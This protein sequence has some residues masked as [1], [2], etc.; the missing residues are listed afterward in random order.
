MLCSDAMPISIARI[1]PAGVSVA[2]ATVADHA[3][4]LYPEEARQVAKAVEKRQREFATGRALARRALRA[5]GGPQ[6]AILPGEHMAPLWPSGFVGSITH[7]SSHAAAAVGRTKDFAGIGIDLEI[8]ARVSVSLAGK[9]ATASE[10][11]LVLASPAP[12]QR[13]ALLYSA[14]ES[15]FKC[16]FPLT[17][18]Y[19]GFDDAEILFDW[20]RNEFAVLSIRND[21]VDLA[22]RARGRFIFD[23]HDVA[24]V[25]TVPV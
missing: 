7:T 11:E 1:A 12:T 25:V 17:G 8:I 21:G 22:Q 9:I 19:L 2:E 24:T 5:A 18:T 3:G 4:D 14:K 6:L 13:L 16:Q 23:D 15:W 20:S 10:R